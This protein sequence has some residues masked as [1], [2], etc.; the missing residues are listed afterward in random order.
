MA[1]QAYKIALLLYQIQQQNVYLAVEM[2]LN[3]KLAI[4][5]N[6]FNLYME[7]LQ[8]LQVPAPVN[9]GNQL[10]PPS[11]ATSTASSCCIGWY[12]I[13]YNIHLVLDL[14]VQVNKRIHPFGT[15]STHFR[16]K[17]NIHLVLDLVGL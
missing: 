14:D 13:S 10:P 6:L 2:D 3:K 15:K 12:I 8:L 9:Q 11:P 1:A 17:G 5:D 4:A 16:D 7:L